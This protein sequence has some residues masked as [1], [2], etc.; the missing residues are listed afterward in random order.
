MSALN[1]ETTLCL[2]RDYPV[3]CERVFDAFLNAEVL[4]EI[5]SSDAYQIVEMTLEPRVGAGWSMVMR[6]Q[7]TGTR[8]NCTARYATIERPRQIVW[9]T[10]WLDGPLANIPEMRVT[11][12]FFPT[13]ESTRLEVTHEF[14]PDHETRDHHGQGWSSGLDRLAEHFARTALKSVLVSVTR[15]FEAPA[16][17]VFDTWLH[18]VA[19]GQWMFGPKLRDEEV[20]HIEIDPREGGKFSF[21]VRRQGAEVDHVGTFCE[22]VRPNRLVFTWGIAGVSVDESVVTVEIT[23]HGKGCELTL[24]HT[25]APQWGEYAERTEGAWSTMLD[26]LVSHLAGQ[27]SIEP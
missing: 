22:F 9:H 2:A 25:L 4:Q 24:T 6:D 16:E 8:N 12:D 19:I 5:W 1:P 13:C 14:F 23:P 15:R 27:G 20:L 3:P 21:L 18:P 11:L 26:S 10:K 7:A 17:L